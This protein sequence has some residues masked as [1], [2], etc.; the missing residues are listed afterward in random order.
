MPQQYTPPAHKETAFNCPFCAAYSAQT[1]FDTWEGQGGRAF[2]QVD[3]LEISRCAHCGRRSI[4]RETKMVFPDFG[5]APLPNADLPSDIATDYEEAR[6]ILSRSPRGAAALLRLAIQ[7]LCGEL[8]E[9]GKNINEDIASLVRKGLPVQVQQALDAVRVI[10]NEA[11]HPGQME[12][13]DSP[14][15]VATLFA[16]VNFIAEKMI[17][18]PKAIEQIYGSLPPEKLAAI[19]RRG[20]RAAC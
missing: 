4:W 15:I 19:Q 11:V 1:W 8:G 18:E 13:S 5:S 3:N 17:S 7:K 6:S 14:E 12:I 10:G 2:S 9:P 16:L 20:S